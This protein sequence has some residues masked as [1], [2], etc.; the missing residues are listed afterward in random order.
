[1]ILASSGSRR[2]PGRQN[3]TIQ[4]L[5]PL[6]TL[7]LVEDSQSLDQR[8]DVFPAALR[9]VG[10]PDV[11]EPVCV[12]LWQEEPP[13]RGHDSLTREDCPKGVLGSV[14]V[15]TCPIRCNIQRL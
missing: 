6:R 12:T 4:R 15:T 8:S 5:E 13:F 11:H 9:T 2:S 14:F 1:M 7:L 10:I 3:T